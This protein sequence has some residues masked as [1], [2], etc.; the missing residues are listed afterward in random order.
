ML[1]RRTCE[2]WT[3]FAKYGNPTPPSSSLP[4]WNPVT[5]IGPNG[6]DFNLHY[7][8]MDNDQFVSDV[9]PDGKRMQ[10]WREVYDSFN[11]GLLKAKL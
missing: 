10:F 11:N 8:E 9:N 4:L 1:L 7:Y 3:N 2:L 6:K 5:K